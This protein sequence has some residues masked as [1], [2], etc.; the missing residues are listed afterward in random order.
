MS[1]KEGVFY[2]GVIAGLILGSIIARAMGWHHLVG[3]GLG[4]LAGAGIG[5]LL[6][7]AFFPKKPD[8]D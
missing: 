4:V 7:T 5:Y 8:Q 1:P 2:A 6:Q 3:L